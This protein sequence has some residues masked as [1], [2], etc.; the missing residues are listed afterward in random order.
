MPSNPQSRDA[1]HGSVDGVTREQRNEGSTSNAAQQKEDKDST[2]VHLDLLAPIPEQK[3]VCLAWDNISAYVPGLMIP[4]NPILEASKTLQRAITFQKPNEQTSAPPKKQV[5][6]S[7]KTTRRTYTC[8]I[9]FN[10][11][12]YVHPGEVAAL[13]GP[14]GSGKTTLISILGGRAPKYQSLG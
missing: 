1:A 9:L 14:S 7:L 6:T 11:G 12:G 4:T 13:M 10:I 5:R 3:R 2:V 8:Q